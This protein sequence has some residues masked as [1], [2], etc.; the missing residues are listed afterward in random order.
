MAALDELRSAAPAFAAQGR[1][2]VGRER[3]AEAI[4]KLDYAI[5]LR[6]DV[7]DHLL[8]KADLLQCQLQ[9]A[10][11]ATTYRAALSLKPDHA[12][13][14]ANA[15]LCDKLQAEL[16]AGAKLSRENLVQLFLAM[17]AEHRPAAELLTVGRMVGEEK[18][19]STA[20]RAVKDLPLPP[21]ANREAAD[22]G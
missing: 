14:Q 11:A 9:F 12:R 5:E 19:F 15:A 20:G 1:S 13:A 10:G 21:N 8:T 4:E 22:H 17:V 2:L 16:D 18:S 7:I 6:P 3:F